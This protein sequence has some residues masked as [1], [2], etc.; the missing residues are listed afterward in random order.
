MDHRF[1]SPVFG[2]GPAAG[3]AGGWID[4]IVQPLADAR[5]PRLPDD[6]ALERAW[7]FAGTAVHAGAGADLLRADPATAGGLTEVAP[8]DLISCLRRRIN[9]SNR[10]DTELSSAM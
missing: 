8:R 9:Q 6:L 7:H 1:H 10:L 4:H 2:A 3:H 5:R